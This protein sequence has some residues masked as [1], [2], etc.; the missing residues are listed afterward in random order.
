M[1][2]IADEFGRLP[3]EAI[4]NGIKIGVKTGDLAVKVIGTGA[5][6]ATKTTVSL[7]GKLLGLR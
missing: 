2:R 6:I 7:L 5:S 1:S 3:E 4:K